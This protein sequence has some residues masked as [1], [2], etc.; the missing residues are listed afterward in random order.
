MKTICVIPARG[1]SKRIPR[2]NILPLNGI[3]LLSY[4]IRAAVQSEVF[5]DVIVSS[6]DAEIQAL[7]L[8]EGVQI[9]NRPNAM[10]GDRVTKVQVIKEYLERTGKD[11][12]YDNVV[13][14]LPTCPFRTVKHLREAVRLFTKYPDKNFLVGV[15]KYDFPIQLALHRKDDSVVEM[16]D[17][18]AYGTTRS[19]NIQPMYHPNGAIYMATTRAFMEQGT[20]FNQEML[21]YEMSAIHSYDIDYPYQFEIA[22]ILAKKIAN[23]A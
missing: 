3:P 16:V 10:A 8:Q 13:A 21:A 1:G 14:L 6:E 9:D 23:E 5:T 4:T 19:Q 17:V 11:R 7:A 2:K 12:E 22:E 18:D 15:T 20:F